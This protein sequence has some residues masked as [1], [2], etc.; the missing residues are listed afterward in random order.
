MLLA[1]GTVL[2]RPL[3]VLVVMAGSVL[4]ALALH[5][6]LFVVLDRS[7]VRRGEV[8]QRSL[9]RHVRMPARVVAV[10]LALDIA[11]AGL[12]IHGTAG[13]ASAHTLG[14]VLV[15][16]V[17]WAIV[18]L[19]YVLEEAAGAR[20]DISAADN[21]RARRVHTQVQVFRR[22]AVAVVS[23]VALAVVLLSFGPIRAIGES[24]LASAGLAGLVIGLAA[25]P[26]VTNLIAGIQIAFTQPIK[27]EDVVVVEGHWGRIEEITLTYVTIRVWDLRRLVVPISYFTSTPFENWTRS[28]A[29]ILGWVH[30]E[31]D[32][33]APVAEIREHL[34]QIL[35]ASPRWDGKVWTLQVTGAGS[36]TIQL[37][38]LMSARDSATSWD[39][40]CEV[41]ERLIEFL[42]EE[43]PY[44]LP[45]LRTEGVAKAGIAAEQIDG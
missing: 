30:I 9:V 1:A 33:S 41:R 14:V 45:R 38:A 17:A 34:H 44:A 5:A 32:Y 27:V 40:Q 13:T 4:V 8:L 26:A 20:F 24:L 11:V 31:V 15:G 37:R 19:T 29:D 10:A 23:F 21:L 7:W 12:A 25:R 22:I 3:M 43:H 16:G 2:S 35:L 18:G 28:K 42:R 36:E 6:A 39:L